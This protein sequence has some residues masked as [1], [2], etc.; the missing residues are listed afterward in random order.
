MHRKVSSSWLPSYIK[1]TLPL[2]EILN[3]AQYFPDRPRICSDCQV[4]LKALQAIR[5]S[6]LVYQCQK[7]L[8]EISALYAVGCINSLDMLDYEATKSLMGS[9]GAALPLGL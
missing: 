8:N 5:M 7:A 3:M 6:F 1:V 9:Q 2:L 4:A